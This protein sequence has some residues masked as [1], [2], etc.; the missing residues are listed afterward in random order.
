VEEWHFPD[1][2]QVSTTPIANTNCR[3]IERLTSDSLDDVSWIQKLLYNCTERMCHSSTRLLTGSWRWAIGKS[4]PYSLPPTSSER[5]KWSSSI[6]YNN[7]CQQK[8]DH[9][10]YL[11]CM[12]TDFIGGLIRANMSE[13]DL[14]MKYVR[15]V[16]IYYS[17]FIPK[18]RKPAFNWD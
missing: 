2:E 15:H 1:K 11:S 9:I 3:K 8:V 6:D 4:D 5:E 16:W 18:S 10:L 17:T 13:P 12:Y 14:D 7:T